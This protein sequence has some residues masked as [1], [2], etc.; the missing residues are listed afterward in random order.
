MI[1]MG[2]FDKP[3][4]EREADIETY[5]LARKAAEQAAKNHRD[6][7]VVHDQLNELVIEAEEHIP[8]WRR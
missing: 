5:K 6:H 4:V 2:W 7:H 3:K 1:T 8:W